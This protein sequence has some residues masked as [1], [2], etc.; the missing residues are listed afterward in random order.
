MATKKINVQQSLNSPRMTKFCLPEELTAISRRQLLQSG[1]YLVGFAPLAP[2]LLSGRASAQTSLAGSKKLIWINLSGGWDILEATDPK[3]ASTSGIDMIYD[4]GLAQTVTGSTAR[5]GRFLPNIAAIGEDLLVIRGLSMG[6]TSHEAGSVYMNTGILSN[7]G[8]VNAA[9]ISAIVASESQATIP[10]IQLGGGSE[11][12]TD[13]GLLNPVSVVRASNLELYRSMYPTEDNLRER[14][15]RILSYL[16]DSA[17]RATDEVGDTDRLQEV[18][19]AESKIRVQVE[20][21]VGERLQLSDEDRAVFRG[22]AATTMN[23]GGDFDAFALTLKLIKNDLV[24]GVNLG[25]GGFDTHAN[26]TTRL[27]P[28][29]ERLDF[30]IGRLV[31]ELKAE[32]KLDETLIVL[33]SDFGRTPKINGS[34][35][36]DHWPTGG[37]MMIGGGIA[38]GRV[39][40]ETD[41]N[42]MAV[43]TNRDTGLPETGSDPI[44]PIHLGG[45]VLSLLLGPSYMQYRPYLEAIP[46]L[47]RLK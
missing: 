14:N 9:S 22:S 42:L 4:W 18:L 45:S 36:R 3:T 13:R 8:T 37:A 11:V 29:L 40:G 33:Y 10:I 16:R 5:I 7:A 20:N 1:S 27:Q 46:A 43:G 2:L 26:Q 30:L 12:A 28:I 35:G 24:T 21:N 34:N 38:G 31:T 6:T 39:V 44:S 15:L 32:G 47:T 19:A 23:G 17:Q 25:V 41:D